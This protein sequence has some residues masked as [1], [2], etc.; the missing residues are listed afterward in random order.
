MQTCL[1]SHYTFLSMYCEKTIY[2]AADFDRLLAL[3]MLL[4]LSDITD[5]LR[6][7]VSD[8]KR[9]YFRFGCIVQEQLRFGVG[10]RCV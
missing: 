1:N 9:N 2:N 6:T 3:E 10:H 4:K 7:S 5:H 8:V